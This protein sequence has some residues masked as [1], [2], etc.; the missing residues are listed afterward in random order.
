MSNEDLLIEWCE[1]HHIS[2]DLNGLTGKVRLDRRSF[3]SVN[4]ALDYVNNYCRVI[5]KCETPVELY[6]KNRQVA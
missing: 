6:R 1:A 2:L 5:G 4:A 3:P